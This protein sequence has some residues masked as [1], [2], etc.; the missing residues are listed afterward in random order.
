MSATAEAR[1]H[2]AKIVR[3]L[4]RAYPDAKCS[5][6]FHNP[7]ELL[8]AT[9]L[10]A[11]CTDKRVNLVTPDLFAKYASTADYAMAAL[12]ELEKDIQ[13]TGFFRNKAK[14]IKG[15]C[16]GLVEEHAGKVPRDLD[17]LVKLPGI[18]RK[19]ANVILGTAYGLAFGVVVDTH[20][21]R[22]SRRMG[23][24]SH[25]DAVK[26]ERDLMELLP[27]TEWISFS[28][29]IIQLGRG[30]CTARKPKC[31][32]CPILDVCPRV[33]VA[34]NEVENQPQMNTDKHG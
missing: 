15:C 13:T 2:A 33:G 6:D 30:P 26:I 18:G 20:V 27:K 34:I 1:R 8:V 10:S 17:T 3:R 5:L 12:D 19:T 25:K 23:L 14:N 31:E 24:S 11:Q 21:T 32:D 22:V 28:H 7:L 9:V 4:A 16:Q 29:R